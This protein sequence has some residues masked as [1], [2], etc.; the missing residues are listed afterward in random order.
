MSQGAIMRTIAQP[1]NRQKMF[2]KSDQMTEA[3]KYNDD[4]VDNISNY[5]RRNIGRIEQLL[6]VNSPIHFSNA[7]NTISLPQTG[8]IFNRPYLTN[9]QRKF[10]KNTFEFV[11]S[12]IIAHE[13]AHQLQFAHFGDSA[14]IFSSCEMRGVYEGQADILAGYALGRLYNIKYE[15][16]L[17]GTNKIIFDAME[18]VYDIGEEEFSLSTHPSRL[19]RRNA[20]RN[21]LGFSIA[22]TAGINGEFYKA[23]NWNGSES[24]I[25][26]SLKTAKTINHY[27]N[28]V[29]LQISF[30]EGNEDT[31]I[32]DTNPRHSVV[33]YNYV[34][35]N[36][37]D[38]PVKV[39]LTFRMQGHKR[40]NYVEYF[41]PRTIP[42]E[43]DSRNHS[44]IIS[45]KGSHT[46]NDSLNWY[47]VAHGDKMPHFV[48]IDDEECMLTA[49]YTDGLHEDNG[50]ICN[51]DN[52]Q[53]VKN[54]NYDKDFLNILEQAN[55]SSLVKF[56]DL[57][58]GFGKKLENYLDYSSSLKI[59][60]SSTT[61]ISTREEDKLTT[62]EATFDALGMEPNEIAP[63]FDKIKGLIKK[64]PESRMTEETTY[65]K[66]QR[67]GRKTTKTVSFIMSISGTS[68]SLSYSFY[69]DHFMDT[70]ALT[71]TPK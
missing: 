52:M 8:V 68:V 23:L 50:D 51:D 17:K 71:M 21:G 13:L 1:G 69:K 9:I 63:L 30:F 62:L 11:T 39:N 2:Y 58:T 54:I 48:S 28:A 27:P 43:G 64:Y 16:V 45:P 6:S 33:K 22:Q 37:S 15:D 4:I 60:Y 55:Q 31:V 65:L 32:W 53:L 24:V 7:I 59:P 56:E 57:K 49:N 5:V 34:I 40:S 10:D 3:A 35:Q 67:H 46:V 36:N 61:V 70:L 25:D 42:L 18:F 14:V 38:R 29:A 66:D 12:F 44:F 41:D 26:W 19:R 47:S 20:F